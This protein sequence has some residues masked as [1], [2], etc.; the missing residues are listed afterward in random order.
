MGF[1]SFGDRLL[2]LVGNGRLWMIA[3]P[4][5]FRPLSGPVEVCGPTWSAPAWD[6]RRLYLRDDS[7]LMAFELPVRS[8][9]GISADHPPA[10]PASP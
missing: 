5:E 3:D 4:E 2:L 8:A 9:A 7:S 1:L 10:P 6:G